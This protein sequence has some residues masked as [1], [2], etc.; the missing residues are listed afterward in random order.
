MSGAVSAQPRVMPRGAQ[1]ASASL[2]SMELEAERAAPDPGRRLEPFAERSSV[3]QV[4]P[5]GLSST[6][7][8]REPREGVRRDGEDGGG[9]P[10]DRESISK[11]RQAAVEH[12]SMLVVPLVGTQLCARRQGRESQVVFGHRKA[13]GAEALVGRSGTRRIPRERLRQPEAGDM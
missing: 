8:Q 1:V 7:H 11:G 6:E 3:D 10:G 9:D 12:G 13:R 5:G 2:A 4:L